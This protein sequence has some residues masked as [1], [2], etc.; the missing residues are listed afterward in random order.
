M[1]RPMN[2]TLAYLV[3]FFVSATIFYGQ[4]PKDRKTPSTQGDGLIISHSKKTAEELE[5]DTS[6]ISFEIRLIRTTVLPLE[7]ILVRCSF[8]NRT[9]ETLE[10]FEPKL[11]N[12][13]SLKLTSADGT[14]VTRK[15]FKGYING[16]RSTRVLNPGETIEE[17]ALLELGPDV[18]NVTGKY[19]LQFYLS[20]GSTVSSNTTTVFVNDPQSLDKEAYAFIRRNLGAEDDFFTSYQRNIANAR[21]LLEDFADKFS[22][23]R[24]YEYAVIG[25][26]NI[27]GVTNQPGKAK[28]ELLK[29]KST[30]S[31]L[32]SSFIDSR[33]A[34]LPGKPN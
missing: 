25:L 4:E 27:Y 11:A 33:I 17:F 10:V 21:F 31:E 9:N 8:E 22:G 23:S 1:F 3:C 20:N 32:M 5:D 34:K 18:L 19:D 28:N 14:E 2:K 6:R 7:P 24:Y 12:S 13:L 26:S 15:A 30:Q 29:L 16:P